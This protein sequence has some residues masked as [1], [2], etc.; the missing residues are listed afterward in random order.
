MKKAIFFDIDGTIWDFKNFIPESTRKAVKALRENGHLTFICSGRTRAFIQDP[1]LFALGF[2]GIVSGC[3]TMIE[4]GGKVLFLKEL[5][6]DL[7]SH[8]IKTV[9]SCGFRP[10]LEG[11]SWLYMDD[12]EFGADDYGKKVIRETRGKLRSIRDYW[13]KWEVS[14]LSCATDHA[15]RARCFNLLSDYYDYCIHNNNVAEF[16]PK[17]YHKG[18]GIEKICSLLDIDI[19]DTV[20]F[21][22]G[23]NDLDMFRT[24]GTS[25][26]MGNGSSEAK[27]AADY[28]TDSLYDDGILKACRHLS[29]I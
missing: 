2:D 8:T 12:D 23:V 22:D 15:D 1:A 24:A 28:V 7:V 14:K 20:A 17:G 27:N 21:G 6:N 10:I 9:R 18:S 3:G 11:A 29:L 13:G 25:V 19:A 16:L 5:D 26:A 4:Y